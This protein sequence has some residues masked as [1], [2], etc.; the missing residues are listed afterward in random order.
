M[1]KRIVIAG[2]LLVVTSIILGAFGAHAL[3]E[4]LK[5]EALNSFEVGVR[6]QVY[7][8]LALLIMGASGF[9]AEI[10]LK[11]VF[12]LLLIGALLFSVSIYLLAIQDLL[13]MSLKFLGP[14]TP[15]GGML[16]IIGW[17]V[18]LIKVIGARSVKSH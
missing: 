10:K 2:I 5:E 18:L 7:H 12:Y 1:N 6:Y 9:F 13:G 11:P 15:I 3:K 4:V 17:F 14:V 8:G 16:M